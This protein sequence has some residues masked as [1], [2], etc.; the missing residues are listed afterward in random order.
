VE[1][2]KL[3]SAGLLLALVFGNVVFLF[4]QQ[5]S[6]PLNY[7][8]RLYYEKHLHSL[9]KRSFHTAVKPYLASEVYEFVYPDTTYG[10]QKPEPTSGFK[11]AVGIIGYEDII[12]FDETGYVRG[13]EIDSSDGE[14]RL[15]NKAAAG[16]KPQKFYISA[17][18]IL[19]LEIGRDQKNSDNSVY[20]NMR[21]VELNVN[22]GSKVSVYSAFTENQAAFPEYVRLQVRKFRAAPGESKVRN[23][24]ER[25]FDFS[26]AMG[27][28]TYAPNKYFNVQAG[29]G[30]HFIGDGFRS[31]FLSDNAF[32]YPYLRFSTQFWKIKYVSIYSEFINE[33]QSETDFTLGLPRKLGSFNYLSLDATPWLQLGAFEGIVW[34]STTADG[35]TFDA[36]FINPI[37][38]IRALQKNLDANKVYGLSAK[39]TL[40]KYIVLYGQ[41]MVNQLKGGLLG[42]GNRSGFQAGAKYYDAFGVKNL[43][44]LAEYNRVRPYTYQSATDTVLHYTHYNQALAHPMGA[45][46]DEMLLLVNYR[47]KRL[48]TE[49]KVNAGTSAIDAKIQVPFFTQGNV[50]SDILLSAADANSEF[51]DRTKVGQ[52]DAR[53]RLMNAEFRVGYIINPKL[54]MMIEGRLHL[55]NYKFDVNLPAL[56]NTD[57]SMFTVGFNTR[58][59]NHYYD[60]PVNF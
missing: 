56:N 58:L 38:G 37:I 54:N 13:V 26:R 33:V 7:H 15:V 8:H 29:H 9:D 40:P 32:V 10:L 21:G 2:K 39:I 34:R 22:V 28:I 36:N 18:P 25:G 16:Y 46:F 50:G 47:Y 31:L 43:N 6:L 24:G 23:F 41:L 17:N 42:P 53:Y 59:F 3:I 45:N 11:K 49:L 20:Y 55:R 48:V 19:R 5:Q 52:G 44:I 57:M 60:L 30:Q 51:S 4:A 27:F 14:V 35:R 12:R 1:K